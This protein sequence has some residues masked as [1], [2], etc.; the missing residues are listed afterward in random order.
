MMRF[1]PDYLAGVSLPQTRRW[2]LA[3]FSGCNFGSTLLVIL[4]Q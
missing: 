2:V 3:F 4:L 1:N